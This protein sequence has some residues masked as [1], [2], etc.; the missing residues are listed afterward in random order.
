MT[1]YTEKW[2]QQEKQTRNRPE[3]IQWRCSNYLSQEEKTSKTTKKKYKNKV[4]LSLLEKS[5]IWRYQLSG[6]AE[7]NTELKTE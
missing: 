3:T 7:S 4:D 5:K 2:N 6:K 1:R